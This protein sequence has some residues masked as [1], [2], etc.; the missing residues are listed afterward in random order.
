MFFWAGYCCFF[1][2]AFGKPSS[3][4]GGIYHSL[5]YQLKG[6]Y[7]KLE[8]G[9]FLGPFFQNWKLNLG[10]NFGE[11]ISAKGGEKPRGN[12]SGALCKAKGEE[13]RRKDFFLPVWGGLNF[14]CCCPTLRGFKGYFF[15]WVF[16]WFP[17]LC[18]FT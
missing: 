16:C 18:L 4:W 6:A 1:L 14:W 11:F 5:R 9:I 15:K 8:V 3:T 2:G 12:F 10:L 13:T 7:T 17:G